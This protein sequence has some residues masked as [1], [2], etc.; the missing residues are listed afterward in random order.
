M[1]N[2]LRMTAALALSFVGSALV[3]ELKADDWD[4]K[5]KITIDQSIDV[6]EPCCLPDRT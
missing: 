1:K 4:K 5:T 2:H 3:P 6:R